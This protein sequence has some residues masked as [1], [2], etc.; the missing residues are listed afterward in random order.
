[1]DHRLRL[2]V[3]DCDGTLVDSQHTIIAATRAACAALDIPCPTAEA[4]RSV[5]GLPF[6]MAYD[7]ILPE[8]DLA[9]RERLSG[10]YR[11]AF[12]DIR[13]RA[14]E[15]EP[16]YS[17]VRA[18]LAELDAAGWLL[19]IATGKT[20]RG[21]HATLD[22]HDLL[23]RFVTTQTADHAPGKPNPQMLL[24]AM[25]EAGAEASATVMIGDTTFDVAMALTAQTKIIGVSWGYHE[26]EALAEAGA[27]GIAETYSEVGPMSDRMVES[28]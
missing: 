25:G 3:F 15:P 1:M 18:C 9:T 5:V 13:A 21:L 14:P 2:A 6:E 23:A 16:L 24:Q 7:Q 12:A 4:I 22:R 10:F 17:G 28:I 20:L 19:G 8:T 26:A 27:H 11:Q